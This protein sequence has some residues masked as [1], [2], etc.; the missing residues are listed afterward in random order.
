MT[1]FGVCTCN[2]KQKVASLAR[3]AIQYIRKPHIRIGGLM[4]QSVL[5]A[6]PDS[7]GLNFRA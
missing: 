6:K 5:D 1:G 4:Q 3:V 2:N 7:A